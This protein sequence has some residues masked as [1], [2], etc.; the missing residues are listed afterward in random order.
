MKPLKGEV[1]NESFLINEGLDELLEKGYGELKGKVLHLLG[2]EA[3]YLTYTGKVEFF[4][5]R[6]KLGFEGLVRDALKLDPNSWTKFIVYRD[7][8]S[9]GYVV[10]EGFGIGIDLRV[11]ERGEYGTKPA[12]FLMFALREGEVMRASKLSDAVKR[13]MRMGKEPM[14]AVVERRGEVIYYKLG[15][16]RF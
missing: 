6:R 14:V 9:R 7:L 11:Y 1:K 13:V 4:K 8:R 5:G 16:M 3:A 12:K 10:K 2:Y 15:R